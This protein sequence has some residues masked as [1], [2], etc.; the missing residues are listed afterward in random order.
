MQNVHST[1]LCTHAEFVEVDVKV[2]V[3]DPAADAL[4]IIAYCFAVVFS[5]LDKVV[6]TRQGGKCLY[7]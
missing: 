2:E 3:A 4:D 6:D 5:S 7:L 1:G